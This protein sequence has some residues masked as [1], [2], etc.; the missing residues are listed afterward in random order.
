M[1]LIIPSQSVEARSA[2]LSKPRLYSV[3]DGRSEVALLEG[4]VDR[5]A[6]EGSGGRYAAGDREETSSLRGLEETDYPVSLW[7]IRQPSSV[8]TSQAGVPLRRRRCGLISKTL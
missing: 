6:E 8:W 5:P 7:N 4:K 2:S 3:K 1:T